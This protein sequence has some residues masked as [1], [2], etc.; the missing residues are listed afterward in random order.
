MHHGAE[1]VRLSRLEVFG[2]K[3]L[4]FAHAFDLDAEAVKVHGGVLP[5]S[6]V[7]KVSLRI[8]V[9]E[10]VKMLHALRR[11]LERRRVWHGPYSE[12]MIKATT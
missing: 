7:L 2:E 6:H 11:E 12:N 5:A 10:G 8:C 3:Q 9:A 1:P 4:Q